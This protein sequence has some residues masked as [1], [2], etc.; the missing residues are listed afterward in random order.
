[1]VIDNLVSE[2]NNVLGAQCAKLIKSQ[3]VDSVSPP[4]RS[5]VNSIRKEI[6]S[7]NLCITWVDKGNSVV[8]LKRGG[9]YD[10]EIKEFLDNSTMIKFVMI[11]ILTCLTQK[12]EKVPAK[13]HS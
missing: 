6:R 8:I 5:V 3:H 13:L 12:C 10:R 2:D 9:D 7:N 11:S 1:M 4:Q